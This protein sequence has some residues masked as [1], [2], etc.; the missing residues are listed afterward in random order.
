MGE[1]K[2]LTVEDFTGLTASDAPSPG[3]GGVAAL[4]GA[5]AA[6]LAEMVANLTIGKAKYA[7]AEEEMQA[8]IRTGSAIRTKLLADIQRDSTCFDGYMAALRMPKDTDEQKAVR[9][10]AMQSG[11]KEAS[12]VPLA[13]A[14]HAA[15]IFPLAEAAVLRGNKS[16]VS[17]G[18]IAAML[19]RTAVL[20]A[21]LNV[22]I[23]LGS[24]KDEA[25][26]KELSERT[27]RLE[28]AAMTWEKQ[29][30]KASEL[31][32]YLY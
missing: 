10:E 32:K 22:K 23:N 21:L 25:L 7:D 6:A 29:I 24:M 5:L 27:A 9:Q 14:E 12:E 16:A 17:D 31:S 13:I 20:S 15:Q 26:A 1:L 2:D 11:L 3:G 4:A 19:A 8:V 30:L 18:L 28:E